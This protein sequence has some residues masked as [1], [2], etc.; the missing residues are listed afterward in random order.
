MDI[1]W[2]VHCIRQAA[3]GLQHA[4]EAG[5]V[6]R[7][8]KPGNLLV[9]RQGVVKILDLGLARF[10]QDTF[11]ADSTSKKYAKLLGTV[12]YISPEQAIN[13]EHVDIRADIYSLGAT[14]HFLLSGKPPFEE[15]SLAQKLIW[16]QVKQP[17]SICEIRPDVPAEL[18]AVI[19]RMMA[20][21]PD[22]RYA[23]PVD[24][25]EALA[26][27]IKQPFTP[28]SIP[29]LI[30]LSPAAK[31]SGSPTGGA[32]I[33]IPRT[34]K[35]TGMNR[36]VTGVPTERKPSS[37][38][39]SQ[40]D[41]ARAPVT[42]TLKPSTVSQTDTARAPATE[43]QKQGTADSPKETKLNAA[44]TVN[45]KSEP[46]VP[47]KPVAATPLPPKPIATPVA[48]TQTPPKPIAAAPA[49]PKPVAAQANS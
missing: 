45:S 12:D 27:W 8:I 21:E 36:R 6:H 35:S 10:F 28:P 5:M 2:A 23:F 9:D 42:E 26:A 20:K 43:T 49:P 13:S 17:R 37:T 4:H 18:G 16:H 47:P 1:L 29:R 11:N 41:T 24:V 40:T 34:P 22:K 7:D 14:F 32:A 3:L 39:A 25:I 31:R 48:A 44:E 46:P 30:K 33:E 19:A 15:G 38:P